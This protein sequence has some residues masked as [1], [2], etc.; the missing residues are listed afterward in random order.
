MIDDIS[1]LA[2]TADKERDFLY[3]SQHDSEI[4]LKV[5]LIFTGAQL[6]GVVEPFITMARHATHVWPAVKSLVI[7]IYKANSQ[8]GGIYMIDTAVENGKSTYVKLV[9]NNTTTCIRA[10]S[11]TVV[12]ILH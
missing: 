1:P 6:K 12:R 3:V 2:L 5:S 11:L 9:D 4:I 7:S 8:D 10:Y